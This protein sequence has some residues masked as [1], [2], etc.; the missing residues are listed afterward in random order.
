M[1]SGT[2]M[3]KIPV[4]VLLV[5]LAALLVASCSQE[6]KVPYFTRFDTSG[7]CGVAPFRVDFYAIAKPDPTGGNLYLDFNWDFGDDTLASGSSIVYHT[8]HVPG[9]YLVRVKV[10][11]DN[12]DSDTDTVTIHVRADT[13]SIFPSS[14]PVQ[15][16]TTADT[17]QFDVK[18]NACGFDPDTGDYNQFLYEW[19]MDNA[20]HTVYRGRRPRHQFLA[21]DIGTRH[22]TVRVSNPALDIVRRDTLI[23]EIIAP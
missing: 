2:I 12:G 21:T 13:L 4:I 16:A 23:L 22:I 6:N 15:T 10:T 5:A 9:E 14:V 17:V 11:D 8:Y 3:K 20:A 1:E 7:N 18:A 19:R